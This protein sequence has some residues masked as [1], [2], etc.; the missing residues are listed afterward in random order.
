MNEKLTARELALYYGANAIVKHTGP[1]TFPYFED[2][3]M[4]PISGGMLKEHE[5]GGIVVLPIL[6]PLSDMTE[7]DARVIYKFYFG[8][9]FEVREWM[10][11]NPAL[12]WIGDEDEIYSSN[13]SNFIGRQDVWR[14]L[15]SCHFDLFGWIEKGLAIDA[16]KKEVLP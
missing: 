8:V 4:Y 7:D 6:R 3:K 12:E 11:E 10:D 5:K 14:Y 13:I 1:D 2:G 9:D 15:L 16:T